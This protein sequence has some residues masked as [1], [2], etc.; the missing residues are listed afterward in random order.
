MDTLSPEET[1]EFFE[2]WLGLL[3]F[4]NDKYAL[5][6]KFGHPKKPAGLDK[7]NIVTLKRKLWETPGVIDEYIDS[8][9]DMPNKTVNTLRGWKNPVAGDFF[10]VRF[11]K[12]YTVF[13]PAKGKILYGVKG[14]TNP[15][16]EVLSP[17]LSLPVYVRTVLLPF[18]GVIIYDSIFFTHP[19]HFG[20][21]M[22]REINETY[23]EIKKEKGILT[24]LDA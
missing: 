2:I 14:I 5:V 8:V 10:I 24:R 4:V 6:K 12:N 15:I 3:S 18:A 9:W 7:D 16:D 1:G 20:S 17:E 11:L 21:S 22:S 13:L 23:S 19:V